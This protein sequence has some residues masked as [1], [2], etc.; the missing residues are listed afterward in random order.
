MLMAAMALGS[1]SALAMPPWGAWWV[2]VIGLGGLY[3]LLCQA[4]TKRRAFFV[5]WGFGFGYFL[6]GLMW[7]GN[8]L[9]VEGNDYA[10]AWPLAVCG[11]PII[12]GVF[13][14]VA[15]LA[16]GRL[17]RPVSY[18]HLTLPTTPYV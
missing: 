14:G 11:L 5:G 4:E 16:A 1:L 8:A 12:L 13:F 10:W 2:L 6:F 9:L 7:I 17:F 3:A 15:T 18:T